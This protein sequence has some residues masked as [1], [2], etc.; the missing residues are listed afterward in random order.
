MITCACLHLASVTGLVW[1]VKAQAVQEAASA[2]EAALAASQAAQEA[3]ID[4]AA[5]LYQKASRLRTE[6][7]RLQ[8]AVQRAVQNADGIEATAALLCGTDEEAT[9]VP[10]SES[11]DSAKTEQAQLPLLYS[12]K[13]LQLW[14]LQC[15]Q[16][17]KGG[18]RD[19]PGKPPDYYHTCYCLSG[20]SSSQHYGQYV[21]GP[22][23]NQ[24][25]KADPLCNVVQ[26][27]LD[28]ARAYKPVQSEYL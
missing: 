22:D 5:D 15:C 12:V 4:D 18:M 27:K 21:L 8:E 2:A 17:P 11:C 19:K 9:T 7:D 3:D 25:V 26:H 23:S 28:A 24:L 13:A 20:L 16:A 6:V 14:L 10:P 1:Q